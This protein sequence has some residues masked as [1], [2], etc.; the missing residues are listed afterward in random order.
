MI[1]KISIKNKKRFAAFIIILLTIAFTSVITNSVYG[2]KDISYKIV[3]VKKG[4]T[5]WDIAARYGDKNT[6]IR[7]TIYD[8]QTLNNMSSSVVYEGDA[9]RVAVK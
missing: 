1:T 9:I 4:D 6:D 7:R 8:I 5:L 2:Y 3:T